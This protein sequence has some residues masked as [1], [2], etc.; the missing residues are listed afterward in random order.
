MGGG[1]ADESAQISSTTSFGPLVL[2][3]EAGGR[4]GGFVFIAVGVLL[5][6]ALP[7]IVRGVLSKKR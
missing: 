6:V 2:E 5:V 1:G 3:N 7:F 4:S